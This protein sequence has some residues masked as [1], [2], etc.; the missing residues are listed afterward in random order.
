MRKKKK[1]TRSTNLGIIYLNVF[2]V[3]DSEIREN[4]FVWTNEV[5]P[6][7]YMWENLKIFNITRHLQAE[8][9]MQQ[10]IYLHVFPVRIIVLQL[11]RK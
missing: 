11:H 10:E 6:I 2:G 4:L 7:S 5:S 9:H 8:S 1:I 3:G